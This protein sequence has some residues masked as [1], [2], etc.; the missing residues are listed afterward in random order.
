MEIINDKREK[1]INEV[2]TRQIYFGSVLTVVGLIWLLRNFDFI[3]RHTFENFFCWLQLL[4]VIGG[5]FLAV[6]NW[7]TG[8]L[9]AGAGIVM[10]AMEVWG[11]EVPFRK[12]VFPAAII[13]TGIAIVL[14]KRR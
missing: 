5:Y 3:D 12:I 11:F 4:V 10:V 9:L 2:R 1:R 7:M 8:I 14:G 13:I 6:K